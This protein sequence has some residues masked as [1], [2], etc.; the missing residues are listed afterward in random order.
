LELQL[1][2]KQLR[3]QDLR[4]KRLVKLTSSPCEE[5]R[6]NG[7]LF[8]GHQW[9][10]A[11]KQLR[12]LQTELIKIVTERRVEVDV[13]HKRVRGHKKAR[14]IIAQ[15][16][17]RWKQLDNLVKKYNAEIRKVGDAN[18]RQ[19]SVK[20]IRENSTSAKC[21]SVWKPHANLPDTQVDLTGAPK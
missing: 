7:K 17:E 14:K 10:H 11:L 6:R 21:K 3:R 2:E 5:S 12:Y 9:T 20:D 1:K 13:L 19:L 8:L 16:N 18:L 4:V 15:I